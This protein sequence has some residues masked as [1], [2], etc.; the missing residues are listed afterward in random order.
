[1]PPGNK[2]ADY[3][4]TCGQPSAN[5]FIGYVQFVHESLVQGLNEG[6]IASLHLCLS[7]CVVVRLG[8]V[9]KSL[10]E[11]LGEGDVVL[12]TLTILHYKKRLETSRLGTGQPLVFFTVYL[13]SLLLLTVSSFALSMSES[14]LLRALAKTTSS[15][16][17][18]QSYLLS[19]K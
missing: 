4:D 3:V 18:Y 2:T 11:G 10:A 1:M 6:M 12:H 13:L 7:Y 15:Y 19:I 8:D 9:H 5:I 14:P 17:H 16:I